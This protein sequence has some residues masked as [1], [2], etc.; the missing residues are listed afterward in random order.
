MSDGVSLKEHFEKLRDADQRALQIKQEADTVALGLA[1]QI[2]TY[3]D[4][5]AD[6]RLAAVLREIKDAMKPLSD[7]VS[8]QQGKGSGMNAFW[9]YLVGGVGLV[10]IVVS[11]LRHP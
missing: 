5:Q 4:A 9:G 7:Y 2:Q 3:K 10:G 6:E 11:L 1:R 8:T